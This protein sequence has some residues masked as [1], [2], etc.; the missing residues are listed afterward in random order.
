MLVS[1]TDKP[2]AE[3]CSDIV[4]KLAPS[5]EVYYANL[6]LSTVLALAFVTVL[7]ATAATLRAIGDV[8]TVARIG[9]YVNS[10]TRYNRDID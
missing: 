9:R 8:E 4:K 3:L 6:I 5:T 10:Y 7:S 1:F 2:E